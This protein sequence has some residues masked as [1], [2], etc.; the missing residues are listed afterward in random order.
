MYI[1]RELE[2]NAIA[3]VATS[4]IILLTFTWL[5]DLCMMAK[6]IMISLFVDSRIKLS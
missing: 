3:W 5:F 6:T 4:M 1:G 2:S